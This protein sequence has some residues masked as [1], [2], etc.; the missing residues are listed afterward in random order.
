M[1]RSRWIK[2]SATLGG[3]IVLGGLMALGLLTPRRAP[4]DSPAGQ[5]VAS[6]ELQDPTTNP[7][8]EE[9]PTLVADDESPEP[10]APDEPLD[11]IPAENLLCWKGLPFPGTEQKGVEPSALATLL[12]A[13]ARIAG[14]PLGAKEQLTLRLF[15]ALGVVVRYPFAI[16]LIDARAKTADADGSAS[17][18]DQLRIAAVVKTNGESGPFRRIIQKVV[19]EQTDSGPATLARKK[20][21]RW[22]YQELHDSRLPQWCVIAWGDLG[23]HFVITLGDGVWAQIAAVA[24][25][26][27]ESISRDAWV[28]KI[29]AQ[30]RPEPLIEVVVAMQDI[31]ARLDPFVQG[32]ATEFFNAWHSTDARRAHW[33]LGFEGR[34]LYCVA[35]YQQDH[36]TVRRQYANP[37][38]R[39]P[40]LLRTIPDESRYA[41][42]N[43]KVAEFLPRLIASFYATRSADYREAAAQLWKQIQDELEI[44][45]EHDALA[46]L[47]G[48]I[49]L[50]NY[51]PHP[52]H[53]P[54]AFTALI[55]IREEPAKVRHTL[56]KLC[57]A[58][59]AGLDK[60]A[61]ESGI[62]SH[63]RL[64]QD[65][66]G[67]WFLQF[68]PVAGLAWTFTD[69]FIVTSWSPA[70][71]R[72]YLD[73]AGDR[74][75][76]RE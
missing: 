27:S 38:V 19:N 11:L 4:S 46:H 18:V 63:A 33:A 8:A 14:N 9:P 62:P 25:G 40:R 58:W 70:A 68:G 74:I 39:D 50:H 73:K 28:A 34:A 47:G 22:Q 43:V 32:R 53:L 30:R 45:A 55:E 75:G 21:G 65:D 60:V 64:Y 66:D 5:P 20:A 71:L 7:T 48:S 13:G 35:H 1:T 2:T 26:E 59:Q 12:D 61:D 49:V 69:R 67:V 24:A 54:L 3:L 56:D 52:L 10:P 42:Y 15:E 6:R 72:D 23:E 17:K 31:R 37:R 41:V 51:P 16:A 44:N 76:Q 29:R 36:A 57:T